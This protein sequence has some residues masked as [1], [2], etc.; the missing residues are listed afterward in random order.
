MF[1]SIKMWML[2]SLVKKRCNADIVP[3]LYFYSRDCDECIKQGF[4]LDSIRKTHPDVWVFT[5]DFNLDEEWLKVIKDA[6]NVSR[7]PSLIIGN[8]TYRGLIDSEH[9]ENIIKQEQKIN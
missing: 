1:L 7:A 2:S 3:V 8:S 6:Y 9:L 4:V 5:I